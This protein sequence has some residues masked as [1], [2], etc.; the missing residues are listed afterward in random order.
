LRYEQARGVLK[1]YGVDEP[2]RPAGIP[3]E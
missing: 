3:V 1:R 2:C